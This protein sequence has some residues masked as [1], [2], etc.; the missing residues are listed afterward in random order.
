[1]TTPDCPA[2]T[3]YPPVYAFYLLQFTSTSAACAM[4]PPLYFYATE[5]PIKG[6]AL[7]VFGDSHV[8]SGT[9]FYFSSCALTR[10]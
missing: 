10:R 1:M 3:L 9:F 7:V 6:G 8:D 2:S 4:S 5:P